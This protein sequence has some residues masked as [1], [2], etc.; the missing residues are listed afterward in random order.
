[1][2]QVERE[3]MALTDAEE[4]DRIGQRYANSGNH[5]VAMKAWL[6]A[7]ELGNRQCRPRIATLF[8]RGCL[9]SRGADYE[10]VVRLIRQWREEGDEEVLKAIELQ[11]KLRSALM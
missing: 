11:M 9:G 2:K 4:L 8:L 10:K 1:M 3:I 6:R 7:A 5:R